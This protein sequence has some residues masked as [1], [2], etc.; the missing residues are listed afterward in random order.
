MIRLVSAVLLLWLGL[1]ACGPVPSE[2]RKV[3]KS[4]YLGKRYMKFVMDNGPSYK[5]RKLS[6][7]STVHY[8]RSDTG[9]LLAIATGRDD[10]YPDVCELALYTDPRGIV[11]RI[12]I[13]EESIR[14]GAV[15]K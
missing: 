8:W 5:D 10:N 1:S 9:N 13:L 15:L 4:L 3:N 2:P 7:G 6:D 11:R 12:Q 14:C